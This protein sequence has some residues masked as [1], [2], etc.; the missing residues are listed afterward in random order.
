MVGAL[1]F[2]STSRMMSAWIGIAVAPSRRPVTMS[3]VT[4][5]PP[6]RGRRIYRCGS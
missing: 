2:F 5:N 6:D 1:S 4:E 3:A